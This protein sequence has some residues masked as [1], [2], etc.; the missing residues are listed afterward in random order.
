MNDISLTKKLL[1][2]QMRNTISQLSV[3]EKRRESTEKTR[4]IAKFITSHT[5]VKT[6]A[7][8][9]ATESELSLDALHSLLPEVRFCYPKCE[10]QG[11]MNFYEVEDLSEMQFMTMGIR[12]PNTEIHSLIEPADIDLFLCPAYAYSENG[13]RLGKGGG[14]YDR[15]LPQKRSDALTLGISFNCQKIASNTIPMESHD[16]LIGQVL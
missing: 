14:Y 8:Y 3:D 12:E 1:R 13:E 4:H 9:A 15:Y 2:K 10:S 5:M 16:L 6:V 7:S 11:V